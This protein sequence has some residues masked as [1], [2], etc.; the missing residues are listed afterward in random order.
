MKYYYSIEDDRNLTEDDVRSAYEICKRYGSIPDDESFDYFVDG[1]MSYNNGDL[2]YVGE[3]LPV[4]FED[5]ITHLLDTVRNGDTF[6][7]D[8]GTV[9]FRVWIHTVN[10]DGIPSRVT[11]YLDFDG[12]AHYGDVM[13]EIYD[14]L[15][16]GRVV[17]LN[18]D[19]I[20]MLPETVI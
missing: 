19:D 8:N 17:R 2:R 3:S 16:A 15:N 14:A 1:C 5:E 9:M 13:M 6:T 18:G 10:D 11:E 12:S 20:T 7:V 4:L